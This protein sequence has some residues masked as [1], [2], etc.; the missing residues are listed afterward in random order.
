MC[1]SYLRVLR[2]ALGFREEIAVG[3]GGSKPGAQW[4]AVQL[5]SPRFPAALPKPP[6]SETPEK[7]GGGSFGVQGALANPPTHPPTP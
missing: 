6:L 1:R 7:G 4:H 3:A 5:G 2:S